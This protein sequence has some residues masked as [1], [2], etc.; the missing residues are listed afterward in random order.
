MLAVHETVLDSAKS[1]HDTKVWTLLKTH[2]DVS[3]I[4]HTEDSHGL[5]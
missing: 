4:D 5:G 2:P 1:V 3:H